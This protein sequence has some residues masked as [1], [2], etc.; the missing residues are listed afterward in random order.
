MLLQGMGKEHS[1]S[2]GIMKDNIILN[3]PMFEGSNESVVKL[4][5]N[6][7]DPKHHL[8][9]IIKDNNMDKTPK[10]AISSMVNLV[11]SP[12]GQKRK[13]LWDAL[14]YT[15][16]VD[17]SPW[18]AISD[19]NT[20][21][22]SCEKRGRRVIEKRCVLFSEFTYSMG[23]HDP[24][25]VGNLRRARVSVTSKARCD[26]LVFGDRNTRFFYRRTLQRRKHNRIVALKNQA[27]EWVMDEDELKQEVV[28]FYRNLYG[29]Q[30]MS[31]SSLGCGTV[32]PLEQEEIQFFMQHPEC[33]SQFRPI[34]LCSFLYKLVMKVNANKFKM[35]FPKIIGLEKAEFII[36]RNINDNIIIVQEVIHSM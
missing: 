5:V 8:A 23:L 17:R 21:L 16:T 10:D 15:V 19:F 11:N 6:F 36:E 26:W 22:A 25:R 31:T 24:G 32:P 33:F 1:G 13:Q 9:V 4:D 3:N 27:M 35:V 2:P 12:N 28:N 30:P 20:I 34:N 14:K 18:L 29:E 7:L